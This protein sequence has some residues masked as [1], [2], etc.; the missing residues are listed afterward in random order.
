MENDSHNLVE[1]GF[2]A[3]AGRPKTLKA[4]QRVME[5]MTA[6]ELKSL[7]DKVS[8]ILAPAPGIVGQV[9][10]C[11]GSSAATGEQA[12]NQQQL[13]LVY[14]SP[15][16]ERFSQ[17]R[18]ESIVAHEFAHALLHAPDALEGGFIE[19]QAD[20]KV[21]SWGFKVAYPDNSVYS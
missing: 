1:T 8:I 11:Q 10:L 17:M 9:F 3:S 12:E 18:I 4:I 14:L 15:R 5:K 13:V 2:F 16:I 7:K 19:Q 6:D 21:R 20:Q